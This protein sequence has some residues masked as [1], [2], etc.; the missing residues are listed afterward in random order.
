MSAATRRREIERHRDALGPELV[1][2]GHSF[3]ASMALLHLADDFP[4]S[5][6]LGL[7]LLAMPFWGPAPAAAG[8][9]P[10]P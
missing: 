5:A 10:S 6:P 8:T 9:G 2:V 7:A 3:G 4:G 1:I